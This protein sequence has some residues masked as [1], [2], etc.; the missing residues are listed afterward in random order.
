M[1]LLNV[2]HERILYFVILPFLYLF[3]DLCFLLLMVPL[4]DYEEESL[5]LRCRFSPVMGYD[6]SN[7]LLYN[8]FF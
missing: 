2:F 6:S 5:H 1:N 7:V 8:S 3:S 4:F